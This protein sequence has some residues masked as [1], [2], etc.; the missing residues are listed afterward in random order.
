VREEYALEVVG[1]DVIRTPMAI[2]F[3]KSCSH[4]R[5]HA[6]VTQVR[7]EKA[8]SDMFTAE[9]SESLLIAENPQKQQHIVVRS[10]VSWA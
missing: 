1:I 7:L 10:L 9:A 6:Y 2:Y 3:A 5:S 4:L 8:D